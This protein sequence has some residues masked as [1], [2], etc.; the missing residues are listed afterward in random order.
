[1][2]IIR[3]WI[4]EQKLWLILIIGILYDYYWLSDWEKKLK[5]KTSIIW[6][7]SISLTILGVIFA[8]LFA[9]IEAIFVVNNMANIRIYGVVFFTPLSYYLVA[10]VTKSNM[11]D[12]FDL[13]TVCTLFSLLCARFDCILSECC[14]GN[15]I[16]DNNHIR[17]PIRE[18]EII[19]Y[20]ILIYIFKKKIYK[21]KSNGE[22]YYIFM[23]SYGILRF[24]LEWFREEYMELI[25]N[26][27]TAHI[28]SL[29]SICIGM[30]IL[31]RQKCKNK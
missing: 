20:L 18:I 17:W 27:H 9:F 13:F 26:L 5:F 22:L 19:Y 11:A 23:I 1:M 28:W 25:F 7:V 10:R 30:I 29:V 15:L 4:I 3:S 31:K 2:E 24:I 14:V 21:N 16:F 8:K 12:I 6:I